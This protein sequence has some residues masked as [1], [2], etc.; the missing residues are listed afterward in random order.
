M[1]GWTEDELAAA[2]RAYR[3]MEASLANG[4][5]VE[6]AKVYRGLAD[7]YGRTPKA[8]EYR[9][10]NISHVLHQSGQP[11]LA[12]LRPA[13]NVGAVVGLRIAK[14]LEDSAGTTS[15][16]SEPS[17]IQLEV[18]PTEIGEHSV[19]HEQ[20]EDRQRVLAAIMRRQGQPDFRKSLLEAYG[21]R[22]AITGYNVTEALEAAHIRPYS[23]RSSNAVSNGLLL[24]ADVHTLFDLY[25]IGVDP[26]SSVVTVSPLLKQSA[27]STIDGVLL[28][29][30]QAPD[31]S[32][33]RS[34][35]A[36]HRSQCPW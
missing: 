31:Q 16:L 9:M 33:S 2:V 12:G 5:G 4:S 23:G 25:L 20:A 14:L 26:K 8:W 35:L 32:A 36:W 18:E 27:Y 13:G 7:L 15:L 6:K 3:Q 22:C 29:R 21:G 10:Q 24:R 34:S 17:R 1:S 19:E 28:S 30:T 11:W